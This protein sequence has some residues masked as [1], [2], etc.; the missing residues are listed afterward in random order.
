MSCLIL[1]LSV[2]FSQS[3]RSSSSRTRG[4][5]VQRVLLL[6]VIALLTLLGCCLLWQVRFQMWHL[7]CVDEWIP[8]CTR[9]TTGG[10]VVVV[11]TVELRLV[12]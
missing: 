1:F 4:T 6:G 8:V 7:A 10:V 2:S 3:L 5:I 11:G 12:V 9:M